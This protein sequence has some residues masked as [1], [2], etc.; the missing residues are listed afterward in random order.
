MYV[1]DFIYVAMMLSLI[2]FSMHFSHRNPRFV[3]YIYGFATTFGIL[4][5]I[6]FIVLLYDMISG[7]VD[8]QTCKNLS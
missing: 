1:I 7:L 2:L 5:I 8:G 6:V 4:A 3:P